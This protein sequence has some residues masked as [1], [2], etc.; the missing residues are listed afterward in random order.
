MNYNFLVLDIE[1]LNLDLGEGVNFG[2]PAGWQISTLCL[3]TSHNFSVIGLNEFVFVADDYWSFM[4][5]KL[6]DDKRYFLL[7]EFENF[8]K[9]IVVP[10]KIPIVTHNGNNFDWPIVLK[11]W[12]DG[13]A[14]YTGDSNS[15]DIAER[16]NPPLITSYE[17]LEKNNLLFD[18]AE[19]LQNRYGKR[20]HLTDL[21]S[22]IH[23]TDN[24]SM[25][26]SEAPIAWVNGEY[27][28]VIDYC[29]QDCHLTA[30]LFQTPLDKISCPPSKSQEKISIDTTPWRQWLVLNSLSA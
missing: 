2:D 27:Q 18:T 1:T 8:M 21:V 23:S 4:P 24:K 7:S 16:K 25:K 13:G 3:T 14:I 22:A 5:K 11:D 17:Y 26:A 20:F 12:T 29:L 6:Q 10:S 19:D 30:K 15:V 28:K 9:W